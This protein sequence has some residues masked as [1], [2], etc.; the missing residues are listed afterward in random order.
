MAWRQDCSKA[1]PEAMMTKFYNGIWHHF[2]TMNQQAG[3]KI[4]PE[5]FEAEGIECLVKFHMNIWALLVFHLENMLKVFWYN[6][7]FTIT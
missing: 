1:S 6:L 5:I 2:A 7:T 3:I 4:S